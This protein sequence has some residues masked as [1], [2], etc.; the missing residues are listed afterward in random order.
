MCKPWHRLT[1][2][3]AKVAKTVNGDIL[4]HTKF[5][6]VF[7]LLVMALETVADLFIPSM[8]LSCCCCNRPA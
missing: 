2:D 3:L 1:T 8:V 4:L 5:V 6:P 7:L